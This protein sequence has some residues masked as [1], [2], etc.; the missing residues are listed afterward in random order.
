MKTERPQ[1]NAFRGLNNVTD[2]LRLDLSWFAQ[3]DNCIV[4]DKGQMRRVDGFALKDNAASITGAYVTEDLQRFY[5]V[6]DGDL[7]QIVDGFARNTL[8]TGLDSAQMNF[9]EVNGLVFFTNGIDRGVIQDGQVQAWGIE[10]PDAPLLAVGTGML[11]AGTYNVLCTFTD[12]AR[13]I[14]SGAGE[15]ASV[16]VE[17]GSLIAITAIP[18]ASGFTT[19]VY[20]TARDG[21]VYQRLVENAGTGTTYNCVPDDLGMELPFWG[22]DSPRGTIPAVYAGQMWIAEYFPPVD[23]TVIW[24]SL[25]LHFHHFNL[26]DDAIVVPGEGKILEGFDDGLLIGTD[27]CIKLWNGEQLQTLADYGVVSGWHASKLKKQ[28]YFWTLRGMCRAMPF[29]NMTENTVSVAP[30]TSAGAAVIEQS[31]MKRYVV[32]LHK[33]GVAYNAQ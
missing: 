25:P 19:N 20:V 15:V 4:T 13:G 24:A 29:E 6:D 7:V 27:R 30:G 21:K 11:P 16:T 2:P 3:A 1:T 18:Q 12:P 23:M 22:I 17:D 14:E 32:A 26:G 31:G 8:A 10:P 28:M 5:V 33:G 9:A